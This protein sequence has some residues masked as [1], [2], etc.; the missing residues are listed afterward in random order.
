[1]P[2]HEEKLRGESAVY[3]TNK[4]HHTKNLLSKKIEFESNERPLAVTRFDAERLHERAPENDLAFSVVEESHSK[5]IPIR[6]EGGA[7]WS[8]EAL[9]KIGSFFRQRF[10]PPLP[11]SAMGQSDT[12]KRLGLDHRD[13]V[14]V[15]LRPESLEGRDLMAYLRSSGIPFIAFS[16]KLSSM[17]T[18]AHIHIGRPSPR[19]IQMKAAS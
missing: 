5:A 10:G 12:H 19:L 1:M 3:E 13:S 15:P 18:G 9:E 2:R 11:T 14:D 16:R 7:N 17:S 4:E 6:Y 8:P